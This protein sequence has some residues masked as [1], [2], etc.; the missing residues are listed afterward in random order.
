MALR[1]LQMS[2][3]SSPK[4]S[5]FSCSK[6]NR[7][8]MIAVFFISFM[9]LAVGIFRIADIA[10]DCRNDIVVMRR[11]RYASIWSKPP[12]FRKDF[13]LFWPRP[14]SL[15]SF[16]SSDNWADVADFFPE[17]G[18]SSAGEQNHPCWQ[19]HYC[20]FRLILPGPKNWPSIF[21]L[22]W[23]AVSISSLRFGGH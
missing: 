9:Q 14:C 16:Q 12:N 21:W 19:Q 3:E 18:R 20:L 5:K 7:W 22:N 11:L 1:R 2:M 15:L 8:D 17:T 23:L 13:D 4:R 10:W 6:F